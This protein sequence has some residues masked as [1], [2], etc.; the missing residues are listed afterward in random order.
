[1]FCN[2]YDED[3]DGCGGGSGGGSGDSSG[4]NDDDDNDDNDNNDNK[5]IAQSLLILQIV[6]FRV[7]MSPCNDNTLSKPYLFNLCF[8]NLRNINKN[9]IYKYQAR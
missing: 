3:E 9:R 8:I 6:H 2:T 4:D 1:M 7:Q 5:Q